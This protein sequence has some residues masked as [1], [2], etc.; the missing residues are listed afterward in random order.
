MEITQS[1]LVPA[2][3]ERVWAALVDPDVLKACIPG[4][5]V[6]ERTGEN[7]YRA[8]VAAKVGPVAARFAGNMELADVT[9]PT[10]YTL[11]FEGQGGAAGFANGSA[12]VGL[13]SADGG[14]TTLT[15]AVKAQVG[16]KLAQIGS[17]LVDGAA[18][19][20]ADDFFARFA[21]AMAPKPAEAEIATAAPAA[22]PQGRGDFVS[23]HLIRIIAIAV[24]IG[25]LVYLYARS[26]R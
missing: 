3:P 7:T 15:Y 25:I 5:E 6:F 12:K 14:H 10:G 19:K 22:L 4:C 20:L 24:I 18:A 8:T 11:K 16:G 2:S 1:R 26:A 13:A 21:A 17:R 9:P 23:R